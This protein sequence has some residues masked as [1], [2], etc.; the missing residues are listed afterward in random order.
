MRLRRRSLVIIAALVAWAS[1]GRAQDLWQRRAPVRAE[2][3]G[4]FADP[5]VT[6]SSGLAASRKYPGILWTIEDSE[7]APEIHAT[8]TLGRGLGTWRIPRAANVDWEAI[9]AGPC[10]RGTCLYIADT[11]DNDERRA[12]AAIYRVPEPDRG[13]RTRTTAAAETLAFRYP[14]GARDVEAM[15]VTAAG[16][17]LL[18]SKGRSGESNLYRLPASAWRSRTAVVAQS[19]GTLALPTGTGVTGRVTDAAM[20]TDGHRVV[21]RTYVDLYFFEKREDDRLVPANPAVVCSVFGLELQGEGVDWL[22]ERRL[23]LSGERAFGV[24]GGISLVECPIQ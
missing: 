6:E 13:N 15:L 9:R 17:V 8:D 4:P 5:R 2:R 21:I 24:A 1:V 10:P 14:D 18:I 7:S 11:G 23:A 16:D 20:A 22:D 3:T 19:L 12:R